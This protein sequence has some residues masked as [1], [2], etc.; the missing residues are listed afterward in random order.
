MTKMHAVYDAY[1]FAVDDIRE[2]ILS[3]IDRYERENA[4]DT[5]EYFRFVEGLY[6]TVDWIDDFMEKRTAAY[7]TEEPGSPFGPSIDR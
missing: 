4:E 1:R 2:D 6:K 5:E 7:E 3:R